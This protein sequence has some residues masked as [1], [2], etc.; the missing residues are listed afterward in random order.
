MVGEAGLAVRARARLW[1]PCRRTWRTTS[2]TGTAWPRSGRPC[3]PTKQSRTPAPSLRG[4]AMSR[5]TAT[6]T[7]CRVSEPS[8]QPA[9]PPPTG[10]LGGRRGRARCLFQAEWQRSQRPSRV[11]CLVCADDHARIKL[12]VESSPSQS[13]YI[14]A[15][16]VVSGSDS[17]ALLSRF[18]SFPVFTPPPKGPGIWGLIS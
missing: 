15:S 7:S 12:K 3:V 11:R 1:C 2:G 13:D 16:P 18:A 5:R 4:R 6:L 17:S 9:P 14:N 10:A 8:R